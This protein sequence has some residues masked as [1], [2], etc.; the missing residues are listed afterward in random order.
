MLRAAARLSIVAYSMKQRRGSRLRIDDQL[1][2]TIA[3]EK[4]ARNS[5]LI[6]VAEQTHGGSRSHW[7]R[8]AARLEEWKSNEKGVD[9]VFRVETTP[10]A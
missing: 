4:L 3:H 6:S 7:C 5:R 2:A 9:K 8:V 1:G 10:G